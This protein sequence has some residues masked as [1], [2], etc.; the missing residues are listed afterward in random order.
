MK[1]RFKNA[2]QA[3][4]QDGNDNDHQLINIFSKDIQ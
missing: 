1:N 3:C 4:K 2:R